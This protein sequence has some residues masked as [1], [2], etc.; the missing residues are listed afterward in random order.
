MPVLHGGEGPSSHKQEQTEE[1]VMMVGSW[2]CSV[3]FEI[4]ISGRCVSYP[5]REDKGKA[6][7]TGQ[8]DEK[9]L[10]RARV[11]LSQGCEVAG[12]GY[13]TM[14]GAAAKGKDKGRRWDKPNWG[15]RVTDKGRN[16]DNSNWVTRVSSTDQQQL[17]HAE[18][19]VQVR[20]NGREQPG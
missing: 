17:D 10:K 12:P 14:S 3:S 8:E 9:D 13:C 5:V 15:T 16:P 20:N 4:H 2:P 19:V 6:A 11:M 18:Q 7:A 1:H